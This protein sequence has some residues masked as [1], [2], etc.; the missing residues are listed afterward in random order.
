MKIKKRTWITIA[1]IIAVIAFAIFIINRSPGEVSEGVSECI[2]KNAKLYTQLGCHACKIQE[3][4]FGEDYKDL[5]VIDC[6]F[7]GEKCTEA[8]ITATPTWVINREKYMGVQSIEKLKELTG[9]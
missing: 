5:N 3:E 1:I 2:G 4:M 7:D 9:C 8:G 6:F